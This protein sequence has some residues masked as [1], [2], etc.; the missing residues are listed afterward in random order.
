[1]QYMEEEVLQNIFKLI[2][3]TIFSNHKNRFVF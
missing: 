1:M 2:A 3:L